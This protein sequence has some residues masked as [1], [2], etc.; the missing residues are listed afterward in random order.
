MN[1]VWRIALILSVSPVLLPADIYAVEPAVAVKLYAQH[2][3]SCH[4]AD[5]LGGIGPAL[6]PE[7]LGR[8]KR[9]EAIAVTRDGR[10]ATQMPAFGD[11]LDT[12]QIAALTS[13]IYQPLPESPRWGMTEINASHILHVKLGQ[14]LS[15]KPVFSVKDPLNLFIVVELGDHHATLLDGDRFEPITRFPTRFALHGGPK[16]SPDG[17]YVYFA[18]RDGWISKY[19]IYNLKFIAEVR[20]GINTRN[21]AVSG[22]GKYVAVANYLP[23]SIVILDARDLAP[24]KVIEAKGH[25]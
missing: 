9:D 10:V 6:L 11:K 13:L 12:E 19:D 18:S 17:R 8:I 1:P 3:A 5:R 24:V 14:R 7:N 21:A 4:G 20:A 15:D 16:Y 22:D 25:G 2:C 23:H